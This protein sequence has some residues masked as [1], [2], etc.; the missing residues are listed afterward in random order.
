MPAMPVPMG[1]APNVKSKDD[2]STKV[3]RSAR[4]SRYVLLA[5]AGLKR[6]VGSRHPP[7]KGR[8]RSVRLPV[9]FAR[10]LVR[11]CRENQNARRRVSF[12][13][14]YFFLKK[15]HTHTRVFIRPRMK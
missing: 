10:S 5:S 8:A 12:M 4:A 9:A 15:I 14:Q 7:P 13:G 6:S 11:D 3:E 1:D 2:E